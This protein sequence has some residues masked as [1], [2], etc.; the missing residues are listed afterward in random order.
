MASDQIVQRNLTTLF[1]GNEYE[2]IDTVS[3]YRI[4][5][6]QSLLNNPPIECLGQNATNSFISLSGRRINQWYLFYSM[7]GIL[8]LKIG[9]TLAATMRYKHLVVNGDRADDHLLSV[10]PLHVVESQ[11]VYVGRQ[12]AT[13]L[14]GPATG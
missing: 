2:V 3:S 4:P 8:K 14:V 11:R 6:D 5:T 9:L 7:I 12:V 1:D 13:H 10:L